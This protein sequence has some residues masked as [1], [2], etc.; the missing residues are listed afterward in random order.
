MAFEIPRLLKA[1]FGLLSQCLYMMEAGK[2]KIGTCL[3]RKEPKMKSGFT[4]VET[5]PP[6]KYFLVMAIWERR[7][8]LIL[9][10]SGFFGA[11]PRS[12][13]GNSK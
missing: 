3:C 6:L 13:A 11:P 9:L 2:R 12:R 1:S 5:V 4:A 10:P 8:A 7:W